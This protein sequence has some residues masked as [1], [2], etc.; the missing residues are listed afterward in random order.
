VTGF[1]ADS[2]ADVR[3]RRARVAVAVLFLSNGALFS[4]LLPRYPEIKEQ[5]GLSN[6][7]FGL[8]VAAFSAGALISGLSA[9]RLIRRFGSARVAVGSSLLLA[10]FALAAGVSTAPV[11]FTAAL[12]MAGAADAV[13][14]VAQNVHGL[15][16]QRNY[17][18]SI[19]NS[20]H[21][22]WS[23][24]AILGGLVGAAAIALHVSRV[25]QLAVS[26]FV[27]AV[28]CAIAYRFLLRG[29]DHENHPSSD[30]A[31]RIRPTATTYVVVAALAVLAIAGGAIEDGGSSWATI[32]LR[33]DLGAAAALAAFGYIAF[34]G[35]QFLG[36]L[37]GDRLVDRFGERAVVRSGGLLAATGMGF[38]LAMPSVPATICGFAAAG[39]GVA[40]VAPAAFHG[41]DSIPGLRAGSGLMLVTWMMRL[42]FLV[43]PAV[44]GTVADATSLRVGLLMVPVAG[45]VIVVCAAVLRPSR[46]SGPSRSARL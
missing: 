10:L 42:G 25:A 32:Y 4:G 33:G 34:V 28:A 11:A 17:G 35:F 12:F 7:A 20:L 8:S 23:V 18:R 19:I 30:G 40:S 43:S 24:G 38:A 2:T 16:V 46:V 6:T 27:F 15:R 5:L 39:F 45:L 41:A 21:A 9:A 44:V 1:R 37:F 14:D 31:A 26:G 22:V 29:P 13:T 3:D 36:R